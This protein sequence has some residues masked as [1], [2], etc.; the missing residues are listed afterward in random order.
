MFPLALRKMLVW[1]GSYVVVFIC[2]LL[3][4]RAA[5]Q[6]EALLLISLISRCTDA[7]DSCTLGGIYNFSVDAW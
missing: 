1:R 7:P 5:P 3:N 2:S 4:R 6:R